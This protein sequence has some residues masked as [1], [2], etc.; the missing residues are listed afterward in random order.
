MIHQYL[1]NLFGGEENLKKAGEKSILFCIAG[2]LLIGWVLGTLLYP[3][4]HRRFLLAIQNLLI[5]FMFLALLTFA[6]VIQKIF[7]FDVYFLYIAHSVFAALYIGTN[8][9]IYLMACRHKEPLA[10]QIQSL[11]DN[12]LSN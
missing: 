4:T 12:L 11:L 3:S 1:V 7:L 9:A 5:T 6:Y 2:P 8:V 10:P